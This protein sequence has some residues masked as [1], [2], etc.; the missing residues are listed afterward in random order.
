VARLQNK[1]K[2]LIIRLDKQKLEFDKSIITTKIELDVVNQ[3]K[4]GLKTQVAFIDA[5]KV[6]KIEAELQTTI[7][8]NK[9]LSNENSKL[10]SLIKKFRRSLVEQ[11]GDRMITLS[12]LHLLKE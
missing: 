7:V 1:N 11:V 3:I 12:H 2:D 4:Q 10:L 8:A 9:V 5:K 6:K